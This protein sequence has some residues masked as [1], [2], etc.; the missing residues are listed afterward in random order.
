MWRWKVNTEELEHKHGCFKLCCMAEGLFNKS[1][2]FNDQFVWKIVY[3]TFD[4]KPVLSPHFFIGR[5]LQGSDDI[6]ERRS[7]SDGLQTM[8]KQNLNIRTAMLEHRPFPLDLMTIT[9]S[10]FFFHQIP[11]RFL[12]KAWASLADRWPAPPPLSARPPRSPGEVDLHQA[13]PAATCAPDGFWGWNREQKGYKGMQRVYKLYIVSIIFLLK[14]NYMLL[15]KN[16][17]AIWST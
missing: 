14:Y 12:P 2:K 1:H 7:K 17:E 4:V 5:L 8:F 15:L 3:E 9:F 6:P 10:P 11:T 13:P 16:H